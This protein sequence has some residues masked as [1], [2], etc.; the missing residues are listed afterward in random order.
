MMSDVDQFKHMSFAN[1]LKLM[2]LVADALLGPVCT[3]EFLGAY[4]FQNILSRMQFKRQS[5]AGKGIVIKVNSTLTEENSFELLHTF[6]DEETAELV[7][8][9]WQKYSVFDL[10]KN[11]PVRI[12]SEINDCLKLIEV[13]PQNLLYKY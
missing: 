6:L 10:K 4:R 5:V 3:E 12:L 7:G 13:A 8:L 1:Y 11:V 9:G 2:Y